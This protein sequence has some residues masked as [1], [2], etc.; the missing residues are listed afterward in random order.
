MPQYELEKNK[1]HTN[2]S[3]AVG[4]HVNA[5]F[6]CFTAQLKHVVFTEVFSDKVPHCTQR[7]HLREN[8]ACSADAVSGGENTFLLLLEKILVFAV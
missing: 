7:V 6:K 1:C 4:T 5:N 3:D 8:I 2:E